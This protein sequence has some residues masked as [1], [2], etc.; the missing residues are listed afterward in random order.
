MRLAAIDGGLVAASFSEWKEVRIIHRTGVA[1]SSA[2]SQAA[3]PAAVLLRVGSMRDL[4]ANFPNNPR[5]EPVLGAVGPGTEFLGA[6]GVSV[7]I[8]LPPS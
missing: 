1:N 4:P 3:M 5:R 6:A 2:S 8:V 7:L